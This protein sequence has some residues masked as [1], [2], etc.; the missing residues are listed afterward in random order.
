MPRKENKVFDFVETNIKI[1][2]TNQSYSLYDI[3]KLQK[4]ERG[5]VVTDVRYQLNS[6]TLIMAMLF[7]LYTKFNDL[8]NCS[9][10]LTFN[11]FT[12]DKNHFSSAS[13]I[14]QVSK[15]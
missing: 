13:D 1:Y 5:A 10:N 11:L 15:Y 2:S 12:D 8:P 4:D 3:V 7:L 14:Q 6:M 9:K